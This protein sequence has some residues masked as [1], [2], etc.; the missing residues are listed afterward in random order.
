MIIKPQPFQAGKSV[1][2]SPPPPPP[3][4]QTW[5]WQRKHRDFPACTQHRKTGLPFHLFLFQ[6]SM[7]FTISP[8][9][10]TSARRLKSFIANRKN[11]IFDNYFKAIRVWWEIIPV[12]WYITNYNT[13][14]KY[15]VWEGSPHFE[16]KMGV[17]FPTFNYFQLSRLRKSPCQSFLP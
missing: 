6:I 17:S 3:C 9:F 15:L 11:T 4:L 2:I 5:T 13:L 1:G 14:P 10:V 16:T 8:F 12:E 7:N